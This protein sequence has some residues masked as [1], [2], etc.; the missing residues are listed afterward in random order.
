[1]SE[2]GASTA[3]FLRKH[4][5]EV[6]RAGLLSALVG[7]HR[8]TALKRMMSGRIE[9]RDVVRLMATL[10]LG[11]A[12]GMVRD[13][14][15]LPVIGAA[16]RPFL[17]FGPTGPMPGRV[18]AG[19]AW[20]STALRAEARRLRAAGTIVTLFAFTPTLWQHRAS[21]H[22]D[23]YWEQRGGLFRL[24]DATGSLFLWIRLRDR[25]ERECARLASLRPV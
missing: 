11:I 17:T 12:D 13:I 7:R 22:P 14:A 18:L 21:F 24:S 6:G 9:P 5:P 8:R 4:A 20:H 23:G 3:V 25:V 15:P 10:D 16:A 1:M 19:W 2:V